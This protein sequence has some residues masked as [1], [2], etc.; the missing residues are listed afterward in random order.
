MKD[1][2]KLIECDCGC[3]LLKFMEDDDLIYIS[4]YAL[5]FYSKQ[6]GFWKNL[7]HKIRFLWA[8]LI[9]KEFHLYE[10]IVKKEEFFKKMED[11]LNEK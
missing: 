10:V 6:D 8:I 3:S 11:F 7:A 5:S 4:H 9:G 2:V 1:V